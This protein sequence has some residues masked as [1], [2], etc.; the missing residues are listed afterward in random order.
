LW[1]TSI[2]VPSTG[3]LINPAGLLLHLVEER[4]AHWP[5]QYPVPIL[6]VRR[7]IPNAIADLKL[8]IPDCR[9]CLAADR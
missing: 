7:H 2:K 3:K 6:G 8:N 1:L 9:R 4:L 5:V